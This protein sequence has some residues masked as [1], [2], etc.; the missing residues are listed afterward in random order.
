VDANVFYAGGQGAR[1][2]RY[3]RSTGQIRDAQ[4]YPRSVTG[5]PAG[6]LKE[7]WQWKFPIVFSPHDPAVLYTSSQ[8]VWRSADEGQRWERISGDLTRAAPEA[9]GE[10]GGPAGKD[11][12][13]PVIIGTV[14]ALG[15]SRR[16]RGLI[17]AGS[18]DGLV[19]VTRDE[20]KAWANV[21][22]SDLPAPSRVGLIEPSPH[23]AATAFFCATRHLEGDRAP[24]VYRTRDY[25]RTWSRV[26]T[27]LSAGDDV[28]VVRE[29]P[30]RAGLLYAGTDHG[31]WV[32]FDA[33]DHWQSL[34][35]DLPNT[36]VSDLVVEAHDLVAGTHGRSIWILDDIDLLRH[37]TGGPIRA[38]TLFP[39]RPVVRSLNTAVIDYYL[40]KAVDAVTVQILDATGTVIR[41]VTGSEREDAA[42]KEA[43]A[44][45]EEELGTRGPEPPTRAQGLNRYRWDLRHEGPTA[46]EE[47]VGGSARAEL[48]PLAVPG[49][50]QVRVAAA[51][52]RAARP[53]VVEIDPRLKGV[54]VEDLKQQ[55]DLAVQVRDRTSEANEAVIRIRDLKAQ[56][57][58]RVPLAKSPVIGLAADATTRALSEIEGGLYPGSNRSNLDP[59]DLPIALT[60]RLA[61]LRRSI[62]TGD[63]RPTD[64]ARTAFA[65]LSAELDGLLKR[66]AGVQENHVAA[67][68][69]LLANGGLEPVTVKAPA[70]KR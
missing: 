42:A 59:L 53:L 24:Y 35:L 63:A 66:L 67:F 6:A 57:A 38:L 7:R 27:G 34:S 69:R 17:W 68:N 58:A 14:S 46:V 32:S 60:N 44:R 39:P 29:D 50:Y 28:H 52:E 55:F 51:G 65:E 5:E 31:V 25:G 15:P 30:G 33:G 2:T 41:Q 37:V 4:V 47:T 21:T 61:A 3:D 56:I 40:P 10:S 22:P 12:N 8:H 45:A 48:G 62:E 36:Q 18:D 43:N 16:A 26:V 54:T 13:G 11:V 1:L 23:D 20:G 9:Q 64:G 19:H 49:A 70:V